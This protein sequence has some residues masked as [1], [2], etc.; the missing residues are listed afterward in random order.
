MKLVWTDE[1][2]QYLSNIYDYIQK[3]SEFYAKHQIEKILS[4]KEKILKFP[5][6]GR[7][8]PEIKKDNIREMIEGNYRI[9]YRIS[10]AELVEY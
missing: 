7:N 1:A 6:P 2:V 3:D 10:S 9:I 4:Y 8:V 5:D